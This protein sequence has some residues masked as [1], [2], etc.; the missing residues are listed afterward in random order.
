MKT[1]SSKELVI[2]PFQRGAVRYTVIRVEY[3]L[4]M[5][6]DRSPMVHVPM[7]TKDS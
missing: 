4:T 7:D 6:R 1:I 3:E 2:N 5:S